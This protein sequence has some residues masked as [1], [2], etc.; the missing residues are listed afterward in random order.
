MRF[1]AIIIQYQAKQSFFFLFPAAMHD[2]AIATNNNCLKIVLPLAFQIRSLKC[3][4]SY[5]VIKELISSFD[6]YDQVPIH[7][8]RKTYYSKKNLN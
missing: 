7:Q 1:F 4:R 2:R 3:W 5:F 8:T 6:C